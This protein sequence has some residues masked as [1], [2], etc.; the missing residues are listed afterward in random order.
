MPYE[1]QNEAESFPCP[2]CG[3]PIFRV[4]SIDLNEVTQREALLDFDAEFRFFQ[5]NGSWVEENVFREHVCRDYLLV[6]SKR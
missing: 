2:N 6:K 4:E 3:W 1:C 5:V